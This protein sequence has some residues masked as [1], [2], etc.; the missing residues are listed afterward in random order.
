MYAY[1]LPNGAK[2]NVDGVLDAILS[3][4]EFPETYLDTENGV[5]LN[6][7]S[8]EILRQWV[9]EIGQSTRYYLVERL[10]DAERDRVAGDFV[11]EI[12]EDMVRGD[13]PGAR[14]ALAQ[15]GWQGMEDFLAK[16]TDG[17]IHGWDQFI[18]DEAWEHAEQ[19]LTNIPGVP[20]Q[21]VFEGCGNCSICELMRKGEDGDAEKLMEAFATEEIM[22][23]VAEQARETRKGR[24]NCC[25][26]LPRLEYFRTHTRS[27]NMQEKSRVTLNGQ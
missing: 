24:H 22:R 5:L 1:L 18:A 9:E 2:I 26:S 16:Q 25:Q 27:H 19:W 14:S 21:E 6:I 7:P 4:E 8:L 3:K 13:V 23:D 12:L 15:G 17:Q 10:S 11:D 20:I